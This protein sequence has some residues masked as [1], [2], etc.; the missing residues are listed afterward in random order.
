[1]QFLLQE[2]LTVKKKEELFSAFL[3]HLNPVMLPAAPH[4][5]LVSFIRMFPLSGASS[6]S[7]L[8]PLPFTLQDSAR[9]SFL[10]RVLPWQLSEGLVLE[11][12]LAPSWSRLISVYQEAPNQ[13]VQNWL[14]TFSLK[15]VFYFR[16]HSIKLKNLQSSFFFL[17]PH[18]ITKLYQFS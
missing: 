17:Y 9:H 16:F 8:R 18:L 11:E 6:P 14:M 5:I 7:L 1:M 10:P 4:C 3:L 15:I 2:N 12:F 13:C